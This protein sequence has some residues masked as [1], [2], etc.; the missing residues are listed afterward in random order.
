MGG[1]IVLLVIAAVIWAV[2]AAANARTK[3]ITDAKKAYEDSLSHLKERPTDPD[4]RQ[5]TLALGR[6]YSNL[7]RDQKGVT[8][9]DEVALSN[10]I[11]A[12]CAGASAQAVGTTAPQSE[13]ARLSKLASLRSKG[14]VTDEEYQAQRRKILNDV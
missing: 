9:F 12:A 10:D 2:V 11:N 4:L 8:I 1:F 7:T 6:A 13:E 14:L 5:H 3:R